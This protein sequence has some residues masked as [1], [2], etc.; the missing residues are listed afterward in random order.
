[1][2]ET[3]RRIWDETLKPFHVTI[4][5]AAFPFH[6]PSFT[7]C[8]LFSLSLLYFHFLSLTHS[9]FATS[10]FQTS[11]IRRNSVWN[12]GFVL[13]SWQISPNSIP[14]SSVISSEKAIFLVVQAVLSSDDENLLCGEPALLIEIC[15]C[16]KK[17]VSKINMFCSCVYRPKPAKKE[18]ITIDLRRA[19]TCWTHYPQ[20]FI[21]DYAQIPQDLT[22]P[23]QWGNRTGKKKFVT[24][25]C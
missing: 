1:L 25:W 4:Q 22:D 17:L 24:G 23:S 3:F 19:E 15:R 9:K 10:L 16:Y 7:P 21:H 20:G 13:N 14:K 5:N 18:K 8:S 11:P 2:S 6:F 12:N